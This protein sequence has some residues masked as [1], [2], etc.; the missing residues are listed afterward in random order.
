LETW[1][2]VLFRGE[3]RSRKG[4]RIVEGE[5]NTRGLLKGKNSERKPMTKKVFQKGDS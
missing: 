4:K 1:G 3:K 5:V 2:K